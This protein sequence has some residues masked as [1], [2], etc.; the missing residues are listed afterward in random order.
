[1]ANDSSSIEQKH[2]SAKFADKEYYFSLCLYN[3]EGHLVYLNKNSMLM[4]QID[5]NLFNP[6]HSAEIIISNDK[7]VLEKG[8]TPYTFLGNGRDIL[9]I[10]IIPIMSGDFDRDSTNE[11][12]KKFLGMKFHFVIIDCQEIT[13][14][15][16]LCKKMTLV[17]Y[18]QYMLSE[19]ICNIFAIQ[20]PS[21]NSSYL[22]TNTGNAKSTGDLIKSIINVVF[23]DG[24]ETD[25]LI[26]VDEK[27]KKPVFESDG[28]SILNLS[29]NGLISYADVLAYILSFHSYKKSPCILSYDRYE[30]K[31]SLTSI[32]T[33][34]QNHEN[35]LYETLYFPSQGQST[36]NAISWSYCKNTFKESVITNFNV[37]AASSKHII[38]MTGN[39]GILS[40]SRSTKTMI[41]DLSVLNS[42]NFTKDYYDLFCKPF[43]RLFPKFGLLPNFYL[44]PNK[45]NNFDTFKSSLPSTLSNNKFLNQKLQSLLYMNTVYQISL[46]GLTHRQP[47]TFIDIVKYADNIGG[48]YKPTKW[49]LSSIGRH[50][51]VNVK[52]IFTQDRYYNT[53][54]TIKPYRLTEGSTGAVDLKSMLNN[55]GG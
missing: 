37:D 22:N 8:P 48:E 55:F 11:E 14:N 29:P 16:S 32:S 20:K 18:P 3:N 25:K 28:E 7:Y 21:G 33:M 45:K 50:F 53:I 39:S 52:H 19:N 46:D 30:K 2:F 36:G 13:Y 41:F 49:D 4:L 43:E 9:D 6:F 1:M 40:N 44:S 12:N 35:L 31:F 34:F 47:M 51:I 10:E 23:N 27:T 38:S 15:N 5:D 54:E 42:D 24:K 26:M 17:E